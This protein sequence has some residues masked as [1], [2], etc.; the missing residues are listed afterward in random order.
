MEPFEA[1]HFFN[2]MSDIVEMHLH[3]IILHNN[4]VPR[5]PVRIR[6][7]RTSALLNVISIAQAV[8]QLD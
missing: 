6:L 3:E 4:I 1:K 7:I 8:L 2:R 5:T